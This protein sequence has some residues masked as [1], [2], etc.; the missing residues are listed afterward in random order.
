[1]GAT[2]LEASGNRIGSVAEFANRGQ[3]PRLEFGADECGA[4]QGRGDRCGRDPGAAA[5]SLIVGIDEIR[6]FVRINSG[7]ARG[8]FYAFI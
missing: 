4:V 5:T 3:Y 6:L 1:M 8:R 2:L 7:P